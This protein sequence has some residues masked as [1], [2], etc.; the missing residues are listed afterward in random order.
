MYFFFKRTDAPI[1]QG[2]VLFN[3]EYKDG[4]ELDLYQ[5]T[6]E[7]HTKNP[8]LIYY[9]GGAWVSGNKITANNDRFNDTFNDLRENGYSIISPDYTLAEFKKSPFPDCIIDAFDVI[10]WI[11]NNANKYNFDTNNVGVLGESA[12]G[13]LALMVA[14]ADV[15]KF[16]KPHAISLNYVAAIY[17]PT[18]LAQLYEDMED[19]REQ[20]DES[21]SA[22]PTQ[23]Q[24]HFD[25]NQYL[26]GFN[27]EENTLK[28]DS[29]ANLFSPINYLNKDIPSTLIIHG[30]KDQVVPLSQSVILKEKIDSLGLNLEMHILDGVDHAFMDASSEQKEQSQNWISEFVLKHYNSTKL[31][32]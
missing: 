22:L 19:L 29:M 26:F 5:P 14:Y 27:P 6:N 20:V 18:D 11:E 31:K 17:P 12:G 13:H 7:A 28:A 2:E 30:N 16:A 4:L 23:L 21:T 15:A 25:I 24:E 9:H 10:S 3:I 8:V 32:K 1:L